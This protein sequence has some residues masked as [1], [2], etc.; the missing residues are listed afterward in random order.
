MNADG[1]ACGTSANYK[2]G[3]R[4]ERCTHAQAVHQKRW[5]LGQ[6][7]S[8]IDGTGTH[9]RI[10]ALCALGWS[11]GEIG[12]ACGVKSREWAREL[13]L[14]QRTHTDTAKRVAAAYEQ[15]SMTIPT[16]PTRTR[17]RLWAERRGWP[18]PLAWDNIDDPDE[19]PHGWQYAE[20]DRADILTELDHLGAGLSTVLARIDISRKTLERWCRRAGMADV[21]SRLVAR[22]TPHVWVNQ[23]GQGGAA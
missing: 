20:P 1:T 19:R 7:G 8:L 11:Y 12:T 23:H 21:Y 2:R 22:E 6:T 3:C 14:H 18:P 17:G 16:G 13:M 10:Q 5:L 4:C 9:R 15:M